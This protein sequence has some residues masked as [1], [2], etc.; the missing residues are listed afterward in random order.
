[1]TALLMMGKARATTHILYRYG[2]IMAQKFKALKRAS[3]Q[4]TFLKVGMQAFCFESIALLIGCLFFDRQQ[5]SLVG[6]Q[7]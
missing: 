5:T 7:P 6:H 3:S 4:R 2:H 1:M